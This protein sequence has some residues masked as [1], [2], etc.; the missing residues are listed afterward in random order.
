MQVLAQAPK[1]V[2]LDLL[3]SVAQ[4]EAETGSG[5]QP[6]LHSQPTV[7]ASN[8]SQPRTASASAAPAAGGDGLS[9]R[10]PPPKP[11]QKQTLLAVHNKNSLRAD[12]Q[13]ARFIIQAGLP[14]SVSR[15]PA[16][17]H[18]CRSMSQVPDSY[19]PPSEDQVKG[20][21]LDELYAET[22][23]SVQTLLKKVEQFGCSIISDGCSDINS[24]SRT[25]SM[26]LVYCFTLL[27]LQIRP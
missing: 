15:D 23:T 11:A 7:I 9:S 6:S 16:F 12:K 27:I 4:S 10:L 24:K 18:L 8:G 21:M 19:L 22:S 20:K 5:K 13:V 3:A 1:A 17:I 2:H 25:A 26:H 14:F